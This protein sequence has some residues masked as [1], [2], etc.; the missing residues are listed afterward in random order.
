MIKPSFPFCW[1]LLLLNN[2][3]AFAHTENIVLT[4][5]NAKPNSVI[6]VQMT[7]PEDRLQ[8]NQIVIFSTPP[9]NGV[10]LTDAVGRRRDD[11]FF[12][13]LRDSLL[14]QGFIFI[15]YLGRKDSIEINGYKVR[16]SD[17]FTK[18]ADLKTVINYLKSDDRFK[19]KD[20]ILAGISEGCCINA[21]VTATIPPENITA[22]IQ[23]SALAINGREAMEYQNNYKDTLF[24]G[25]YGAP[26]LADV[27]NQMT[28][29]KERDYDLTIE[30]V[31]R[32]R[33]D[34]YDPID[35]IIF[36]YNDLD[37]IVFATMMYI[38]GKW[39]RE[40]TIT[41]NYYQNKFENYYT[42]HINP[43]TNR[44]SPWQLAFKKWDPAAYYADIKCPVL[45][46]YGTKD[47][48]LDWQPNK[49]AIEKLMQGEKQ[50]LKVMVL[51]DYDHSLVKQ[52]NPKEKYV[53]SFVIDK[54]MTWIFNH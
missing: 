45:A 24:L 41:K 38:Q 18:A 31:R 10:F 25:S 52:C 37:S 9:Y 5:D 15:E 29:L 1:C 7:F 40:K 46:I 48:L 34:V 8:N 26:Q 2:L 17:M 27:L 16:N 23:L 39:N 14:R 53:E 33:H 47:K 13:T 3:C 44:L 32:F 4:P 49:T 51:E 19:K 11:L 54:I 6:E 50:K 22:L 20:I 30:G 42:M 35:S 43:N 36:Q 12:C 21:I 28:S